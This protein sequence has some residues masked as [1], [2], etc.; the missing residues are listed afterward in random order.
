LTIAR[1]RLCNVDLIWSVRSK[2]RVLWLARR[3]QRWGSLAQAG[4]PHLRVTV[5]C[6]GA[7][8][9]DGDGAAG[10]SAAVLAFDD[11]SFLG[12]PLI[13]RAATPTRRGAAS[14][15]DRNADERAA[16]ELKA[17]REVLGDAAI[18]ACLFGDEASDGD[19]LAGGA[20][21]RTGRADDSI[22]DAMHAACARYSEGG[23]NFGEVMSG[24]GPKVAVVSCAPS[25]LDAKVRIAAHAFNTSLGAASKR[26]CTFEYIAV[27][28]S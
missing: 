7:A 26:P 19:G 9:A 8:S 21:L 6:T 10:A 3:L 24:A 18:A 25:G 5:H 1:Q 27:E 23:V 20:P 14:A 28:H 12:D 16:H 13:D 22:V 15:R 11:D 4:A 2:S 17:T